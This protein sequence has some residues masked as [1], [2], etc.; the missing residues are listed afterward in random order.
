MS[1]LLLFNPPPAA[2]ELVASANVT[3]SG[4]AT[5]AQ[6][7]APADKTT[8]DFGGGRLQDDENPTDAVD[9]AADEYR[10]DEWV[11]RLTSAVVA[12]ESYEF[13]VVLSDGTPLDTYTVTPTLTVPAGA[14]SPVPVFLN[15]Y[16]QMGIAG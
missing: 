15:H 12:L 9:L 13:R 5:T 10:E 14:Q 3:A 16:R 11:I 6:L 1:L 2:V 4:E 8:A 7:T